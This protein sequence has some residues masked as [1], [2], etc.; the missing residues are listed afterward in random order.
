MTV[1]ALCKN[2]V[3]VDSLATWGEYHRYDAQKLVVDN[4]TIFASCGLLSMFDPMVTWYQAGADPTKCPGA[5]NDAL[6]TDLVVIR[7]TSWLW[8][9][10]SHPYVDQVQA[11]RAFGCMDDFAM[12]AMAA[13]ADAVEAVRLCCAYGTNV[14]GP[15]RYVDLRKDTFNVKIL[16]T[17]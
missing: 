2:Y 14:G 10:T 11:P 5:F 12:G 15:V 9:G 6:D 17:D 13:G 1:I 16:D 4:G 7:P 8:C 3:A